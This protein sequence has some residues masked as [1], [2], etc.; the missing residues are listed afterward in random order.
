MFGSFYINSFEHK[1]FMLALI[2]FSLSMSLKEYKTFYL[3]VVKQ[4][5]NEL[6]VQLLSTHPAID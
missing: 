1:T 6:K 2:R 5:A 3:R 4:K